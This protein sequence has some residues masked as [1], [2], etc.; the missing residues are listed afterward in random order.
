MPGSQRGTG[1]ADD[2]IQP[3]IGAAG[4]Y[5]RGACL[6]G[7]ERALYARA[8]REARD[9]PQERSHVHAQWAGAPAGV[10][11]GC[12]PMACT[13][14]SRSGEP[15][16]SQALH[17]AS[18]ALSTAHRC[19]PSG[20]GSTTK[21]CVG[22]RLAALGRRDQNRECPFRVDSTQLSRNHLYAPVAALCRESHRTRRPTA[23]LLR[24]G[25][26]GAPW[27]A[28]AIADE[29]QPLRLGRSAASS[30]RSQYSPAMSCSASRT[31]GT[32]RCSSG[33]CWLQAG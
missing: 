16:P 31:T 32:S 25:V 10:R 21:T 2:R 6:A 18:I 22:V 8:L 19:V 23:G 33:A 3:G 17:Y 29:A 27:P 11:W 9:R 26:T 15:A 24:C 13:R 1:V 30:P 5:P 20:A 4:P 7:R 14:G 28:D 12:R